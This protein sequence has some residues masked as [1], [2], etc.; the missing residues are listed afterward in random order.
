MKPATI[1]NLLLFTILAILLGGRDRF[2]ASVLPF[3]A[4][5]AFIVF[6]IAVPHYVLKASEGARYQPLV[7]AVLV[8]GGSR[9][10]GP[11]SFMSTQ[12][13]VIR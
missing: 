7:S 3:L 11:R 1:T 5:I 10:S 4:V 8:L 13:S 9:S 12:S 2:F 6:V